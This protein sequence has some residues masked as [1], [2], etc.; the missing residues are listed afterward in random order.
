MK[1]KTALIVACLLSVPAVAG[2]AGF[3]SAPLDSSLPSSLSSSSAPASSGEGGMSL[4]WSDEF[5][6]T[7]LNEDYWSYMIGNGSDYGVYE[8]GNNEAENYQRDN[9]EVSDGFLHITAKAEKTKIGSKE[10]SYTSGRIRTAGKVSCVYG[11]VEARIALPFVDGMWPAFWMLPEKA[12]NGLGW[13]TS[14]EIDIMENKG[15]TDA[16]ASSAVHYANLNGDHA[17]V[18]DGKTFSKR[19]GESTTDFHVYSCDWDEDGFVFSCDG[20]SYFSVDSR[21]Y[22]PG[23]SRIYPDDDNAPFNAPFHILLNLA[24]GGNFDNG[25]LPPSGFDSCEM[26]VDYVRIYGFE[27]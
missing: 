2:C 17:Y 26:K 27:G 14:G 25:A 10:Y 15:S 19:N 6:G 12:Y 22:H 13:P 1:K 24:V 3:S 23:N 7:A 18:T 21:V 8:W 5:D 11:R 4:V 9:V 20:E 16:Y